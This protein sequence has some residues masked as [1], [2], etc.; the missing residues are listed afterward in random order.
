VPIDWS[1]MR[2]HAFNAGFAA[3]GLKQEKKC[4]RS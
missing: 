4:A 2:G 1:G 3:A